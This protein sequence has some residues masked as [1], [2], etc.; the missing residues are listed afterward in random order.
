MSENLNWIDRLRQS[1]E[2]FEPK[3]EGN[4]NAMQKR[5][6]VSGYSASEL[7]MVRRVKAA[8][9]FAYGASVVAAGLA[10]WMVIPEVAEQELLGT[11]LESSLVEARERENGIISE[12]AEASAQKV[13]DA[14]SD[15][16]PSNYHSEGLPLKLDPALI[17]RSYDAGVVQLDPDVTARTTTTFILNLPEMTVHAQ[18]P[19]EMKEEFTVADVEVNKRNEEGSRAEG[20][21]ISA[22][23]SLEVESEKGA[24]SA[25]SASAKSNLE[26]SAAEEA[27]F[28]ISVQEACAGTEVSFALNGMDE[29]ASVLWNFGDGGFSQQESPSHIYENAG[30]Y[31]ITVSVR[32]PGDGTIRTRSV[33]NMIVVRPKPDAEMSWAF[34]ESNASRVNVHL[35]DETLGA[36]SSTWIMGQ[37]DISS[38]VALKI[39]GEYYVNLVASNAFG[40]QDVAVEKIQLGDR[41]EANAPAMFSPDG[42]GRYD[43]FMPLTVMD[44]Q[45]DW[46]LTVWDGMEVVFETNDVR[47]P[48]DGSLQDGGLS[49]PGKSYVW[50][51]QTTST[52]GDRCLFVDNVLIDGE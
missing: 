43:T 31:D 30:T 17:E 20:D 35:F 26:M 33:E 32:A 45:D 5:L 16:H 37:E 4:W 49:V 21:R 28:N 29:R 2:N 14:I 39:P 18:A 24:E 47:S 3:V 52:T 19:V 1:F 9:R 41:K 8:R 22:T 15:V 40:C 27:G 11:E 48:W 12:D 13:H 44:L 38:S 50:K 23:G 6:D 46:N 42:D 25:N 10:L 36:S 34:E 7:D 51:L